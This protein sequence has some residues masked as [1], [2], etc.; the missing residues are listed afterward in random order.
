MATMTGLSFVYVA[1]PI[2]MAV[3]LLFP[4]VWRGYA[5][6]VL[7]LAYY[8]LA[9]PLFSLYMMGVAAM[10]LAA[11][12]I[13]RRRYDNPLIRK[14][15]LAFSLAKN[16]GCIVF[17]GGILQNGSSPE[18]LLGLYVI[19]LSGMG[20]VL[21]AYRGKI[22]HAG[23]PAHFLLYCFYFPR[24][25][26][27]PLISY[28][29]FAPQLESPNTSLPEIASGLGMFIRGAVKFKILGQA[30]L[31]FYGTLR[32]VPHGDIS[33]AGVWFA[34][35]VLGLSVYYRF[36]G[37]ADMARGIGRMM[38]ISLPENFIYPYQ[39]KSVT[40]FFGR[41]N[42][43][44]TTYMRES[45]GLRFSGAALGLL[46]TG[47]ASGL[48]FGITAGRLVWGL[49]LGLF[50]IMERYLYPGFFEKTPTFLCRLYTWL[51][52]LF[53]FAIFNAVDISQVVQT[54]TR[55]T[56]F[57]NIPFWSERLRYLLAS[58]RLLLISGVLFAT[59]AVS[60]ALAF[61]RERTPTF[62]YSTLMT[63][64]NV[65]LLGLLTAFSV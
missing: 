30:L 23:N 9:F 12:E 54:V 18:T 41:F 33:V 10:D 11:L 36:S 15:C 8:F 61:L 60:R 45:L 34:V 43:T 32:T 21:E 56:G 44:L 40:D 62:A 17:F 38:G 63:F 37:C 53:S 51:I 35:F 14:L 3:Y 7:S 58:N 57:G 59:S 5:L 65:V 28:R 46:I 39:S 49:Y 31:T 47:T 1:L 42:L 48:W 29:E 64:I 13:M 50:L 20:C 2:A 4:P 24:L 25:A 52:I 27:G 55:M 6:L 19:T 26:A 16:L 22:P